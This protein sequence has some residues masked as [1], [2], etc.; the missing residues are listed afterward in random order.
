V[1]HRKS[2]YDRCQ[3]A[4]K[5][6]LVGQGDAAELKIV[7]HVQFRENISALRDI[8]DA[9]IEHLPRREIGDVAA[10]E[11]DASSAHRQ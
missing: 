5:A 2:P 10:I 3:S 4:G 1:Q 8:D 7:T 6:G 9:G 11:G